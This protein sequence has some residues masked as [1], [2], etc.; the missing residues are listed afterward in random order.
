MSDRIAVFHDGRIEQVATPVE[1]YERPATSFVAGFVG[2]SNLLE[3]DVAERLLGERGMFSVRPEKIRLRHAGQAS[4]A[5]PE[6]DECSAKG[7]VRE[8]VYLGAATHSVVELDVGSRLTVLQQNRES[9]IDH[10]LAH[11][12]EDVILSWQR[13]HVVTLGGPEEATKASGDPSTEENA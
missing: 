4:G 7:T 12:G 5:A 11:R 2:T 8:V 13:G 10:A 3:G 9:S 6:E 1:L